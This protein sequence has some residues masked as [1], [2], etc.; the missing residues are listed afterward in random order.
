[1]RQFI[2][3]SLQKVQ[4][5]FSDKKF[6]IIYNTN[7]QKDIDRLYVTNVTKK[8]GIYFIV[9]SDFIIEVK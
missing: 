7:N 2:G 5:Y 6:K 1:M 9:V 4:E 8:N 3:M